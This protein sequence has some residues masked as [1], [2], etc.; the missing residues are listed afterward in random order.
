MLSA[1][2]R[3]LKAFGGFC[4]NFY[5]ASGAAAVCYCTDVQAAS[6][7]GERQGTWISDPEGGQHPTRVKVDLA[8]REQDLAIASRVTHT[9][10]RT[11]HI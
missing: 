10:G 6:S 5:E 9:H 4:R 11:D 1:A 7:P 2:T 3:T 8:S